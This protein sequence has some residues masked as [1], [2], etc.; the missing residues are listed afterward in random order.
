MFGCFLGVVLR[1]KVMGARGVGVVR[2]L[3]MVAG[4]VILCRLVV[5]AGG[6]FM[7]L[8]CLRVMLC[9]FMAH[10]IYALLFIDC[11]F[12]T[13]SQSKHASATFE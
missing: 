12:S 8:S 3:L 7:V 11:L 9:A 5:M 10:T 6:V 2:R 13:S 4:C 1:V